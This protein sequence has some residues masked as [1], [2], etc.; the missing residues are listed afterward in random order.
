MSETTAL[1]FHQG[2][3][4]D[5]AGLCPWNLLMQHFMEEVD[6]RRR[7]FLPLSERGVKSLSIQ[8]QE[9]WPP[10]DK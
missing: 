10:F 5:V 6:I 3:W 1:L 4:D 8:L 7:T 9:Q 2:F